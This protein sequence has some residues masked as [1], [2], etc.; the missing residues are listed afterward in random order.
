[1]ALNSSFWSGRSVFLTGHT[2]FKGSWLSLWLQSMG[3]HVTGYSLPPATKPS[4]FVEAGI[5]DGMQSVEADILNSGSLLSALNASKPSVVFHLAAQ[6]LVRQGY[7]QPVETFAVNVLGTAQL[8]DAIRQVPSVRAVVVVTSDKCYENPGHGRAFVEGDPLGGHDP[9]SS[10]KAC[11]ELV[12]EAMR[13]SYFH[14][15]NA[16]VLASVRAGNVIGGGDWSTDRLV[17]DLIRA[18]ESGRPANIRYPTATR[19]WQ[20]VLDPLAGYLVLAQAAVDGGSHV[21]KAWNFGPESEDGKPVQWILDA[22]QLR[23]PDREI[24]RVTPGEHA[25]EA[26]RLTLNSQRAQSELHWRPRLDAT[27]ALSW[28][29]DWYARRHAGEQVRNLTLAQ[30]DQYMELEASG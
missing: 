30:I 9:Y 25:H 29:F 14:T 1:M 15:P 27:T 24:W 28:T 2:G 12:T 16:A 11:A 22:A 19:P 3:A 21:A 23:W 6:S 18:L 7:S 10:S 5:G 8:L 17:P 4:L 20:H 13:K 26:A